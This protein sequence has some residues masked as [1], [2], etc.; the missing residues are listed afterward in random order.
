MD[1]AQTSI[2]ARRSCS[3]AVV[4]AVAEAEGVNPVELS[5]PLYEVVDPDALDDLFAPTTVNGRM[6][7]EVRFSYVGY[8]VTV[9]GD[10]YVSVVP[11]SD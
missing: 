9:A 3:K 7:G 2:E 1:S 11:Q 8:E 5:P 10:G 6:D 4:E